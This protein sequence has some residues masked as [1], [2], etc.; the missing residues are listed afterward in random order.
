MVSRVIGAMLAISTLGCAQ[1]TLP[2]RP[3][4]AE[5]EAALVTSDGLSPTAARIALPADAYVAVILAN[6]AGDWSVLY[7]QM[8]QRDRKLGAGAHE[9]N[10]TRAK[11]GLSH[12]VSGNYHEVQNCYPDVAYVTTPEGARYSQVVTKCR[13]RSL[14]GGPQLTPE[15]YLI[16]LASPT[17]IASHQEQRRIDFANG[18]I[19]RVGWVDPADLAS[20]ASLLLFGDREQAAASIYHIARPGTSR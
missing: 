7:P 2:L 19:R 6:D 10:F 9:I 8:H 20:D 11:V 5:P 13:G 16:V 15:R 18:L 1:I 3:V 14:A 4:V 12:V 17:P